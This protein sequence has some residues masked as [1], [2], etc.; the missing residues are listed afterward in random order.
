MVCGG[1]FYL[2]EYFYETKDEKTN[3]NP[4]LSY[5]HINDD[6]NKLE[7]DHPGKKTE[8]NPI[9]N[10]IFPAEIEKRKKKYYI[11]GVILCLNEGQSEGCRYFLPEARIGVDWNNIQNAMS[12]LEPITSIYRYQ[13]RLKEFLILEPFCKNFIVDDILVAAHKVSA[14]GN[15]TVESYMFTH[16]ERWSLG[17]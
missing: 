14:T 11:E 10:S 16:A 15:V 2:Q 17:L 7:V 3:D 12:L 1:K 4:R 5:L 6:S 8:M 13:I 9:S